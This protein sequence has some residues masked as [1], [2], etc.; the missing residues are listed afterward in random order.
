LSS[1]TFLTRDEEEEMPD[2]MIDPKYIMAIS[3]VDE[4]DDKD[5]YF[6]FNDLKKGDQNFVS[7]GFRRTEVFFG[8]QAVEETALENFVVALHIAIEKFDGRLPLKT[9]GYY[10]DPSLKEKFLRESKTVE[11][12]VRAWIL[13]NVYRQNMFAERRELSSKGLSRALRLSESDI[14]VI[15]QRYSR[16]FETIDEPRAGRLYTAKRKIQFSYAG[17][18]VELYWR[19][20]QV[21]DE[22]QIVT[23]SGPE[24][25]PDTDGPGRVHGTKK[26]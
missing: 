4:L 17:S 8:N 3:F 16:F 26:R 1:K 7:I 20:Q 22:G 2:E 18:I 13:L 10:L 12:F 19:D 14:H 25:E 24:D 15:V 9:V 5:L 21:N 23:A 6:Y 11:D